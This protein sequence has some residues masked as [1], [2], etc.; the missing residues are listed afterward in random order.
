M[1]FDMI[2]YIYNNSI[3]YDESSLM[4][5]VNPMMTFGKLRPWQISCIFDDICPKVKLKGK[6]NEIRK[7]KPYQKSVE[8]KKRRP[9]RSQIKLHKSS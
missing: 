7:G 5:F 8:T 9:N 2:I 3:V 6:K 1:L 4:T